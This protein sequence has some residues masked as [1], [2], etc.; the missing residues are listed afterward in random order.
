MLHDEELEEGTG[1]IAVVV[2]QDRTGAWAASAPD[3]PG[4]RAVGISLEAARSSMR[5][6]IGRELGL[7]E[8]ACA[9]LRLAWEPWPWRRKVEVIF[10]RGR[11]GLWWASIPSISADHFLGRTRE[12]ARREALSTLL[13]GWNRRLVAGLRIVD[14]PVV[15]RRSSYQVRSD[16]GRVGMRFAEWVRKWRIG[17]GMNDQHPVTQTRLRVMRD[18]G[19]ER[20]A[21]EAEA[22]LA[23]G[24]YSGLDGRVGRGWIP[25][26]DRLAG[27]L[28]AMGWDR[29]LHKVKE[30]FGKLCFYEGVSSS[31]MRERIEEAGLEAM[32][33]C[34]SCGRRGC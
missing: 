14:G 12:E 30:K 25:V 24:L 6:A 9:G 16:H 11:T 32:D 7:A 22:L 10:E 21:A 26:L 34:E 28:V 33:L 17:P 23:E 19:E 5:K 4:A 18:L 20:E 27:D 15:R 8:E 2:R 13:L 1:R 31:E 3:V 29:D